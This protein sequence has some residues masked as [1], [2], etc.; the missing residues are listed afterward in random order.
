MDINF[1][2]TQCPD[3]ER[4][5]L[6]QVWADAAV[7]IFYSLGPGWGGIVNM[8]SY[9]PLHNNNRRCVSVMELPLFSNEQVITVRLNLS[10]SQFNPTQ[11]HLL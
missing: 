8:A 4:N 2:G 5:Q 1:E 6:L 7:Q 11:I 10:L 3:Y 9:N